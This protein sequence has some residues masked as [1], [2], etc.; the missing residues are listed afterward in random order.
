[1]T[2]NSKN[3]SF[4]NV[5]KDRCNKFESQSVSNKEG[6]C[7][8]KDDSALRYQNNPSNVNEL[9]EKE[10]KLSEVNKGCMRNI[11]YKKEETKVNKANKSESKNNDNF[12]F[13]CNK[14]NKSE[15][16]NNDNFNFNCNK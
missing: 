7:E 4:E 8:S 10:N 16:K 11:L 6:L 9:N 5:Q 12:N 14:V 1:M 15:S 3:R 13:N 2:R